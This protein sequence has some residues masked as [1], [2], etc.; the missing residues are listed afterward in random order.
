MVIN[1]DQILCFAVDVV[2]IID[3]RLYLILLQRDRHLN[4]ID[5]SNPVQ[6]PSKP[7]DKWGVVT[8]SVLNVRSGT[9]YRVIGQ[10]KKCDKVQLDCLVGSWWSTYYGEHRG[11]VSKDYIRV[12]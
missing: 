4:N 10:L 5:K 3:A 12:L 2:K 8:T 6:K 9:G 1:L 7:A 11:F